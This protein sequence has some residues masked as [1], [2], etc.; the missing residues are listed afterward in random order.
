[1]TEPTF[2]PR[3]GEISVPH[4]AND[5]SAWFI[6]EKTMT[7]FGIKHDNIHT[8][9]IDNKGNIYHNNIKVWEFNMDDRKRGQIPEI[10]TDRQIDCIKELNYLECKP[11]ERYGVGTNVL[12]FAK[13]MLKGRLWWCIKKDESI[14]K[15]DNTSIEKTIELWLLKV[16]DGNMYSSEYDRK[17]NVQNIEFIKLCSIVLEQQKTINSLTKTIQELQ[18]NSETLTKTVQDL[19]QKLNTISPL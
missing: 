17:I 12:D 7:V 3:Y 18:Q 16:N 9:H 19:Q 5:P 13:N 11:N 1:M 6:A 10:L 4:P 14:A 2:T 8:F 15:I